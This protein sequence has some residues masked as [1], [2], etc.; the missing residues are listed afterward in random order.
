MEILTKY[1]LGETI[2]VIRES[3]AVKMEIRSIVISET[4]IYYSDFVYSY[5]EK[6]CFASIDELVKYITL[7]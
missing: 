5:P 1:A 6:E 4:G 7:E 2:Y 3:K